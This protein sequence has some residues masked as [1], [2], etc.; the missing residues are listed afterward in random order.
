MTDEK[1][2]DAVVKAIEN[3]HP[4]LPYT[5]AGLAKELGHA[6]GITIEEKQVFLFR[7]KADIPSRRLRK[8]LRRHN[9][10]P[11]QVMTNGCQ[12]T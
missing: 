3:E 1:L 10:N 5:D 7:E 11:I 12:T 4:M 2:Y 6:L 9:I 8:W